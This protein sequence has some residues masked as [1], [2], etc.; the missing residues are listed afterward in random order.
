MFIRRYVFRDEGRK[1]IL[2]EVI[3]HIHYPAY[4]LL[5]LLHHQ[6]HH[7]EVSRGDTYLA[8]EPMM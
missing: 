5:F 6:S 7:I 8:K 3:V 2:L 1:S 4:I